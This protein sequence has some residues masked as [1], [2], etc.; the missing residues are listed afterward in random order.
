MRTHTWHIKTLATYLMATAGAAAFAAELAVT[1]H[2]IQEN[3]GK[4][5]V[6]IYDEANWLG[7]DPATFAG[8]KS[9]DLTERKDEGPLVATIELE[10]GEYGAFVYH[11]LN[12]N[13]ELD[14]NFVGIPKE[15]YAFSQD[16]DKMKRPEFEDCKFVVGEDGTAITLTLRD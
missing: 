8:A 4:V 15:P 10:P 11:D 7:G 5:H 16:F 6:V 9:V 12:V 2:N 14:R 1:V 3:K 13:T